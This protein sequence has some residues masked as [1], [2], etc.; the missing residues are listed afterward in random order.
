M[1]EATKGLG[2]ELV[3]GLGIENERMPEI[4]GDLR[5]HGNGL[6]ATLEVSQ[7]ELPQGLGD[8]LAISGCKAWVLDS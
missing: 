3:V 6:A 7:E 2:A 5:R 1:Q 4:V 8:Q